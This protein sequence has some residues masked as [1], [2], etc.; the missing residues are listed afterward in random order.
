MSDKL[1]MKKKVKVKHFELTKKENAESGYN[2]IQLFAAKIFKLDLK[3][4]YRYLFRVQY[5]GSN[6]L[7]IN[8]IVFNKDGVIF[9]VLKEV[10]RLAMVLT[11]DAHDSPPHLHGQLTIFEDPRKNKSKLK[12][13]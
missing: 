10:N 3:E 5:Y 6:T 9:I 8:D 12:K 2:K 4:K 1:I 13:V 7:K 11:K